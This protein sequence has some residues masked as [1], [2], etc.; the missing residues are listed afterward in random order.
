MSKQ[1]ALDGEVGGRSPLHCSQ[2]PVWSCN[3]Y[4]LSIADSTTST[5]FTVNTVRS[6]YHTQKHTTHTHISQTHGS[7]TFHIPTHTP[8]HTHT[9][10]TDTHLIHAHT[11]RPTTH[12]LQDRRRTFPGK[13]ALYC[14][15]YQTDQSTN[16][17]MAVGALLIFY[18]LVLIHPH[19]GLLSAPSLEWRYVLFG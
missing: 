13:I 14:I 1:T 18:C 5:L 10:T 17:R 8:P 11:H 16:H 6:T 12:P 7:H 2:I 4:I 9:H 19:P 3:D 15:A